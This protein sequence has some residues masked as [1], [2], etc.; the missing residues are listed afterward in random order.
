QA[1]RKKLQDERR[2][3]RLAAE[4]AR[5]LAE[6]VEEA[7][8]ALEEQWAREAGR[9]AER[10]RQE[11]AEARRR[12]QQR[13]PQ[14]LLQA[15]HALQS[16]D[17]PAPENRPMLQADDAYLTDEELL[18]RARKNLQEWQRLDR[19]VNNDRSITASTT[20]PLRSVDQA[21]NT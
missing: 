1:R 13:E 17:V 15:A 12:Q 4:R 21:H 5:R 3:A 14:A 16:D 18:E 2:A 20:Q 8:Q 11:A 9:M 19:I 6:G 7:R 10:E